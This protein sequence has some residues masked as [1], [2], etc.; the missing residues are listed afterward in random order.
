[1]LTDIGLG[2]VEKLDKDGD[3]TG[4]DDDLGLSG[5][6]GGNVGESPGGLE[7]DEGMGRAQELDE[8]AHDAGLDDLLDRRVALFAEQFPE[9][10][11]GLDLE[12]NLVREDAGDHLGEVLIE[13][14]I[15]TLANEFKAG[16]DG[17]T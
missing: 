14:R 9:L 16:N 10:C 8:A 2:A 17:G 6:A 5:R 15:L 13:L 11:G 7:L 1:L 4:L 3:G 12:V